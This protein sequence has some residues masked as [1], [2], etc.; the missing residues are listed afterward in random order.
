MTQAIL[1]SMDADEVDTINDTL[2]AA[3][4]AKVIRTAYY[5]LFSNTDIPEHKG[6]FTLTATNSLTPTVLT[7]PETVSQMEWFKYNKRTSTD[8]VDVWGDVLWM[9][10][11]DFLDYVRGF[12]Q[13]ATTTEDFTLSINSFDT[14]IYVENDR[15]PKYW[16]SFDDS[17]IVCDAYDSA[18]ET[19]LAA[20]KTSCYGKHSQI[21]TLSDSFTPVL[22]EQQFSLLLNEAKSLAFLEVKQVQHPKAEKK[23]REGK[24]HITKK[25]HDLPNNNKVWQNSLPNYGRR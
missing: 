22:D 3:Q 10:P 11:E 13:T 24:I 2:E 23:V 21:F 20:A 1:S 12:D 7:R 6:P 18:V 16:T 25:K 9:D 15:A 19:Y 5:D 8:T 4:V 14:T 17:S